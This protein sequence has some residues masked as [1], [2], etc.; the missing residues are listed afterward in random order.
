M[1]KDALIGI[2]IYLAC[3]DAKKPKKRKKR[4]WVKE[5]L[6]KKN[7]FSD[8]NLLKELQLSPAPDFLL[9]TTFFNS[10]R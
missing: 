5:W 9:A 8:H 3:D 1:D 2:A 4:F 7:S 10:R 6:T